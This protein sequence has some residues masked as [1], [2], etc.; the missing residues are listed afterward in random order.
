MILRTFIFMAAAAALAACATAPKAPPSGIKLID[1]T[2]DFAA[3]WEKSR[4]LDDAARA[5][6]LKA[7]FEPLLPGFYA[8]EKAGPFNYNDLIVKALREYPEKRGGIEE[9]SRRFQKLLAPA[10]RSFE[11]ALGPMGEMAP[12]YLLHS[13]GEMDGGVRTLNGKP[14]MFFGADVIAQNHLAH[15]IQPFF[16]HELFHAFH[17]RHFKGCGAVWCGLWSEGLAVHVANS[18][19]PGATDSELLMTRPVPLRAAIEANRSQ[20]I[21]KLLQRL[22]S[23]DTG[24]LFFGGGKD[25]FGLPARSGYYIGYLAA[26]EAGKTRPLRELAALPDEQVRPLVEASLRSLADCA[27]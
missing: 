4:A 21:C 16:H 3:F 1:L 11:A 27:A 6:A 26:A 12:I 18:L 8:R 2:D 10:R 13:L 14:T 17:R 15:N 25:L 22:D 5:P 9:V 19:N 20:A 7:H 23:N 24:N